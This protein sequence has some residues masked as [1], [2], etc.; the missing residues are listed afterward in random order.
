MTKP[1]FRK[2]S[3]IWIGILVTVQS[4]CALFF[5][6]EFITEVFGLRNWAVTWEIREVLQLSASLG[7]SLGAVAAVLLLRQTILRIDKAERQVRAASGEF[8]AI[9]EECFSEWGLSPSERDVALFAVRGQSNTEIAALRG[10]SE[11]TVKTQMNAVFRKAAVTNRAQLISQFVDV[12]ITSST[13]NTFV[14]PKPD[15]GAAAAISNLTE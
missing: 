7:L 10:T 4:L 5:V 2:S 3:L 15:R 6:S 13:S 1:L 14:E 11:A 9:M 8:F 12:L